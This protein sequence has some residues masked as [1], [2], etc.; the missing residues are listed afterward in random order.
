MTVPQDAAETAGPVLVMG[1]G[2]IGCYLGGRLQAAGV[3]VDF[4][5]R[6][7]VLQE[8]AA[9]GL[10]LTDLSGGTWRVPASELRLH[11]DVPAGSR[12]A[13]VLLCVKRP[14]LAQALQR[15][16]QTLPK[17]TPVL[18]WQNGL[19][20]ID[21]A[22]LASPQLH[23]LPAMV[24]FNVMRRGPGH[25]HQATA[26]QLAAQSAACLAPWQAVFQRAGLSLGLHA[27]MRPVQWGKLLLN[28]NNPV[29]ALSG[30]PLKAQ[31]LDATHRRRYADLVTEALALLRQAH[32]EPY[33]VTPLEWDRFLRVL[34]LPTPLFRLIAF[35]MLRMD[36]HAR[37]SM[38]ED[39]AAGRPTEIDDLC[40][41]VVRLGRSLGTQAPL[42]AAMVDA[43]HRLQNAGRTA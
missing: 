12:P 19:F 14:A 4:V 10:H 31:L 25:F 7:S 29:N 13:L 32:I 5:G 40:G 28:L 11:E 20:P 16:A 36:A 34:R 39:L 17:E 43:I 2:L 33:R 38:A 21:A 41:E 37:S 35:R 8:L 22:T 9:H 6:P 15:L 42:N 24:P 3:S 30:L 18:C 26:G 23:L 27:D 1:A